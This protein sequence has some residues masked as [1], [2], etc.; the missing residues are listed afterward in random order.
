MVYVGVEVVWGWGGNMG[1][2]CESRDVVMVGRVEWKC[3]RR[4]GGDE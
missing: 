3:G 4:W 2:I 1:V